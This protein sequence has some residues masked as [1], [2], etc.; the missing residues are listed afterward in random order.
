MSQPFA[1]QNGSSLST[2][3]AAGILVI[4]SIIGLA[5]LNRLAISLKVG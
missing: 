4:A 1:Q 3:H 2:Q 5:L